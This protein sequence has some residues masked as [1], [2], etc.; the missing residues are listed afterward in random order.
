SS[1]LSAVSHDLRT[2]LA[3]ITG[4]ATSLRDDG[5]KL[6]PA[7][8]AEV[9]ATIVEDAHRLERMLANLL[10]LTRVETGLEPAREWVPADELVGAALTRREEAL[11]HQAVQVDVE[12]DL[13]LSI[14]PVLF[15]QVLINLIEN[16][17]KHA[18][19]PFSI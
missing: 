14:D 7:A 2:P 15:E 4:A 12:P 19:P 9:L 8:R 16:A 13:L 1:L 5:A 3:V 10:Q 18:S 6:T 11:E 17:I